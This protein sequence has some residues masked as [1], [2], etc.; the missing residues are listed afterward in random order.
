MSKMS[1]WGGNKMTKKLL[2]L[3]LVAE[4]VVFYLIFTDKEPKVVTD[5][6]YKVV[7]SSLQK[8][9]PTQA[10]FGTSTNDLMATPE[11]NRHGNPE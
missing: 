9:T 7:G 6:P 11:E 1:V 5:A 3:L 2:L 10:T 4:L 8:A